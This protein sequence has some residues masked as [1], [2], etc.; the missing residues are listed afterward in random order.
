M[1][2]TNTE[3]GAYINSL[4]AETTPDTAND[5]LLI[6]DATDGGM[7][8]ISPATI[9]GEGSSG[10]PVNG[11]IAADAMTYASADDPTYTM[12]CT[13][14]QST[15]Y[16][17][18]MRIKLTQSTGG[19]KYFV[20]TKVA[21]SSSTT[22]T[23]YGGTD[24]NLE[25]EAITN[26][27]YSPCKAPAAFPLDPTKWTVEVTDTTTRSQSSPAQ[28]TWYNLGS[29]TISIPIGIWRVNYQVCLTAD[30]TNQAFM[31]ATL[32]TANNSESDADFTVHQGGNANYIR[33]VVNREKILNLASK[34][35]YYL[36]AS[37]GIYTQ[38]TI[39]FD[40]GD[41]KLFI[42]ALCAYL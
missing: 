29:T 34:T 4:T 30:T 1:T 42:R 40:N 41:S 16:Y 36:N 31:Y 21:Y 9:A 5:M 24:Y 14:D 38:G 6:R 13:G 12:T 37:S 15:K 23:L 20:I 33:H 27:Y 39:A 17:A 22:L 35:A 11:W 25:N 26:P 10:I 3:I 19:T 18:G 28:S 8:K 7:K 32:S 2:V